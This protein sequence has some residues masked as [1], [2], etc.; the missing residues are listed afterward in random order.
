MAV[1]R[2]DFEKALEL[3]QA[4]SNP[5]AIFLLEKGVYASSVNL[6]ISKAAQIGKSKGPANIQYLACAKLLKAM[7]KEAARPVSLDCK[8]SK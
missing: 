2:G 3:V 8:C 7:V 5:N 4:G 6:L 1:S